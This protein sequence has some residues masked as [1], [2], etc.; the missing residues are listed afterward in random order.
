[1]RPFKEEDVTNTTSVLHKRM[2]SMCAPALT[3]ILPETC[4]M[5]FFASALF[6]NITLV[7]TACVR[8]PVIDV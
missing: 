6:D 1:M 4:H 2:P 7:F 8:T 3:A 5:M